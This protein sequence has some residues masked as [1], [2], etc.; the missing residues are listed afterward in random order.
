MSSKS[1]LF[2]KQCFTCCQCNHTLDYSNCME[3]PNNEIYCKTCYVK[4]YFTGGRNKFGDFKA[5]P[6]SSLD[7]PDSCPRCLRKVY[8]MERVQTSS[9]VY[10]KQCMSC[11]NCSRILDNQNYFDATTGDGHIYCQHCYETKFGVKGK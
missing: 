3:G 7:D 1:K 10:H 9:H 4:E 5:A 2:H 11:H 6:E 8:E